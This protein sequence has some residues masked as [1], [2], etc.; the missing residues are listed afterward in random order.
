M[1]FIDW[2]A[3]IDPSV[4]VTV[5]A[6]LMVVGLLLSIL[7]LSYRR[8]WSAQQPTYRPAHAWHWLLH[9]GQTQA[10]ALTATLRA[11]RAR[12]EARREAGSALA[13]ALA[14]VTDPVG[15][16]LNLAPR[17]PLAIGAA[18]EPEQAWLA[19]AFVDTQTLPQ[20]T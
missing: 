18:P 6:A 8:G 19:D 2:M 12:R 16:P 4:R 17:P 1:G 15:R 10:S 5:G 9:G 3:N 14:E 13:A 11:E 20:V 7:W